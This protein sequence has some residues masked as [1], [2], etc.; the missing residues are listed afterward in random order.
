MLDGSA[1][2]EIAELASEAKNVQQVEIGDR[3]FVDKLLTEIVT[4]KTPEPAV[5]TVHTLTGF[6]DYIE[7]NKDELALGDY[8]IWVVSPDRVDLV[9][10]RQGEYYQRLRWISAENLNRFEALRSFRFGEYLSQE[11]MSIGLQALFENRADRARVLAVVGNVVAE[12]GIN[13]QDDGVSQKVVVKGGIAIVD[14]VPVP[15][16]VRLAPFRTFPDVG[17]QPESPFVFRLKEGPGGAVLFAL[18]EADGGAWRNDAIARVQ[19][20]LAGRLP[21]MTIIA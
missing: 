2:K 9:S 21:R 13:Q 3:I 5:I 15:N 18:F 7:Q 1:V 8:F 12:H 16:P 19:A 11:Q 14:T 20:W 10:K 6:A 17:E 4:R